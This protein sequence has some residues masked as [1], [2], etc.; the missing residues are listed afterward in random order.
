M[1]TYT[2]TQL[3]RER[4]EARRQRDSHAKD[5][6][7]YQDAWY[8]TNAERDQLRKVVDELAAKAKAVIKADEEAVRELPILSI[9]KVTIELGVALTAYNSL[10]H[11]QERNKV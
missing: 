9:P 8:A 3:K 2:D 1:S 5:L 10:P 4:D 7:G 11:V 6:K